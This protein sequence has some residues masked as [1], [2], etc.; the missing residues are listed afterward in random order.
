MAAAVPMDLG[1]ELTA[2]VEYYGVDLTKPDDIFPV[3]KSV[4]DNSTTLQNIL[5]HFS[6]DEGER[7]GSLNKPFP[8]GDGHL[9]TNAIVMQTLGEVVDLVMA[10]KAEYTV[11]NMQRMS[12]VFP[13]ALQKKIFDIMHQDPRALGRPNVYVPTY[14]ASPHLAIV[15]LTALNNLD[16]EVALAAMGK[17]V[18]LELE[19]MPAKDAQEFIQKNGTWESP[20]D[21]EQMVFV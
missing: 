13:D 15:L 1:E 10:N 2:K 21:A 16:V 20:Y 14:K 11:A 19:A 8:F 3:P 7:L 12:F 18:A 6:D 4:V 9:Y 17:A 5:Q